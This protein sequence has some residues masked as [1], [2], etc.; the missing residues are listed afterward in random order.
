MQYDMNYVIQ[1]YDLLYKEYIELQAQGDV[2][3]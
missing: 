2:K 3:W 1:K